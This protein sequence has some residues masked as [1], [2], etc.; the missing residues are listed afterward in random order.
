MA[1][2]RVEYITYL[3]G[4]SRPNQNELELEVSVPQMR[5]GKTPPSD[6]LSNK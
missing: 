4:V 5:F 1:D 3:Q 6:M 2:L